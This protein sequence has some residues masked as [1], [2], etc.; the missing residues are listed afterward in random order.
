MKHIRKMED[1]KWHV[2]E[3]ESQLKRK[4]VTI[5]AKNFRPIDFNL[6]RDVDIIAIS[7][8]LVGRKGSKAAG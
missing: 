2:R 7:K 4:G 8:S 6:F 3:L 1:L 5:N